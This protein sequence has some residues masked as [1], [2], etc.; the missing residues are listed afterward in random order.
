M[1]EEVGRGT[2]VA[3]GGEASMRGHP[4]V[5]CPSKCSS[6][7]SRLL[8]SRSRCVSLAQPQNHNPPV[9]ATWA[10]GSHVHQD[11]VWESDSFYWIWGF[12]FFFNLFEFKHVIQRFTYYTICGLNWRNTTRTFVSFSVWEV[13]VK[14]SHLTVVKLGELVQ[15]FSE[16][17]G[18]QLYISISTHRSVSHLCIYRWYDTALVFKWRSQGD[19]Q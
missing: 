16:P 13:T 2:G 8:S 18:F 12:F 3:D 15:L 19:L 4:W 7:L 10:L 11:W 5:L 6:Q 14:K 17:E 1:P 9:S